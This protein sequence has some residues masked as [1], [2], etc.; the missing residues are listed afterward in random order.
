MGLIT[1]VKGLARYDGL[2]HLPKAAVGALKPLDF[3]ILFIRRGMPLA[4][5][6]EVEGAAFHADALNLLRKLRA[7]RADLP[8]EFWRDEVNGCARC[9][10]ATINGELAGV[11]W[12]YEAPA[13]RPMIVLAPGDAELTASFTLDA[14]RGRGLYRALLAFGTRW[15]LAER[16]RL[17]TIVASDNPTPLKAVAKTGYVHL[18]ALHRRSLFGPKFHTARIHHQ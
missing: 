11:V 13:P 18:D 17:F 12:A 14:F 8:N 9:C 3:H 1:A 10:V 5:A 6:P 4:P 15:Q 16:G 7:G 2:L